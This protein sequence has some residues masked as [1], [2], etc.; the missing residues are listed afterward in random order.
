MLATS[1]TSST[2]P[3]SQTATSGSFK[4]KHAA[5]TPS[6]PELNQMMA[7]TSLG[8]P[9]SSTQPTHTAAQ[10]FAYRGPTTKSCKT[11]PEPSTST[12]PVSEVMC[13][14][15]DH[16]SPSQHASGGTSWTAR[17]Q[18]EDNDTG[19]GEPQAP[20][21][22]PGASVALQ[23]LRM[24]P[25]PPPPPPPAHV[26]RANLPPSPEQSGEPVS[27]SGAGGM[28]GSTVACAASSCA[29]SSAVLVRTTGKRRADGLAGL[30]ALAR[31]R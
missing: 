5:A 30:A 21:P 16:F 1:A 8:S 27:G 19:A 18:Q 29:T 17:V 10:K 3:T 25:L 11:T 15:D 23:H 13:I 7:I 4:R 20:I 14:S 2:T 12:T 22:P 26:S 31:R 24:P 28:L 6:S 9:S